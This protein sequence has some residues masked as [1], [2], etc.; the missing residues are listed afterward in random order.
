[1]DDFENVVFEVEFLED[2][3]LCGKFEDFVLDLLSM[4]E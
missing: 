3:V 4:G 1:M 2:F